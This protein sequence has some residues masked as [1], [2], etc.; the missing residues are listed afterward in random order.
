[1]ADRMPLHRW[2]FSGVHRFWFAALGVCLGLLFPVLLRT[3]GAGFCYNFGR[4]VA[5]GGT[6]YFGRYTTV[7]DVGGALYM[8]GWLFLPASALALLL[9]RGGSDDGTVGGE[10][11]GAGEGKAAV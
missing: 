6:V 9:P 4:I 8:A 10:W 7:G 1:M 5:A 2:P 3:T 11:T